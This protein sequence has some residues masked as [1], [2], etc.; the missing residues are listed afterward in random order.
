MVVLVEVARKSFLTSLVPVIVNSIL[1]EHQIV[2][3]IVAFVTR[4]AF[5]RSRLGEKQRG[6]ILAGW[7]SR[8][9][10]TIAQWAIRDMDAGALQD[11]GPVDH[12]PAANAATAELNRASIG[13]HRSSGGGTALPGGTSSLRNV[14]AA[15]QILEQ[16]EL[17]HR[18]DSERGST[19]ATFS[20]KTHVSEMPVNS[21]SGNSYGNAVS[22]NRNSGMP[23]SEAVPTK[24]RGNSYDIP[25]IGA[26]DLGD[27]E[28]E[29]RQPHDGPGN[30]SQLRLSGIDG[31]GPLDNDDDWR[32]DA[33]MHMNL[34][35]NLQR[36]DG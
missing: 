22:E 35:S 14:E 33:I 4:G 2:V 12:S 30:S 18:M 16:R 29:M 13:S 32:N 11:P 27:L 24:A 6:K 23:S 19:G 21:A 26:L 8:K 17:E 20:Y 36:R 5:P 10:A 3:D 9:M 28:S 34:A 7:V 1:N 15:P 31:R 25:N